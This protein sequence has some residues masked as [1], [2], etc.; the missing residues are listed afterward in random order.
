MKNFKWKVALLAL[1]LTLGLAVGAV[2]LR[3]RQMIHEPLF[4]RIS[5]L[6]Y[7]EEVKLEQD[8]QNVV[9]VNLEYVDN[10]AST[11]QELTKEIGKILGEDNYRLELIDKRDPTLESAF[12]AVHLSLYEGQ[13]RG[14]FAEVGK[15]L[16]ETLSFYDVEDHLL[17][18][19]D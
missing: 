9:I 19:D 4:K 13:Q 3:Q 17:V 16:K 15:E 2:Y 8:D 14:N 7:V 12:L 10:L 18:V 5:E 11:Y 6:E 1:I